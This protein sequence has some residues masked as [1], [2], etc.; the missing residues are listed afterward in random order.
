VRRVLR[1]HKGNNDQ[2]L[3]RGGTATGIAA[4]IAIMAMP[5]KIGT[6]RL[7]ATSEP[8]AIALPKISDFASSK[9]PA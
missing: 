8:E 4:A 9:G 1:P 3:E 6:S 5:T 7:L 2:F